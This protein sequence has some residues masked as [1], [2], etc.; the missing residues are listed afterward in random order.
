M[1]VVGVPRLKEGGAFL[2]PDDLLTH[3][4]KKKIGMTVSLAIIMRIIP[5]NVGTNRIYSRGRRLTAI[6]EYSEL[7]LQL[8]Q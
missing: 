1:V 3:K 6:F 7:F 5:A 2:T 4:I 8:C